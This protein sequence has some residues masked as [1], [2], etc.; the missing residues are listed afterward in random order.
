MTDAV[1]YTVIA[2]VTECQ[3]IAGRI[4]ANRAAIDSLTAQVASL[5][6]LLRAVAQCGGASH[7]C[8]HSRSSMFSIHF[9][10]CETH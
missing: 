5:E 8:L 7:D 6:T 3:A 9:Q 10:A 4:N 1:I 2:I